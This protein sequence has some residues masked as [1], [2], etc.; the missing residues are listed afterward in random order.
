MTNETIFGD[1]GAAMNKCAKELPPWF[2][3]CLFTEEGYAWVELHHN[4]DKIWDCGG[5]PDHNFAEK[6]LLALDKAKKM[7]KMIK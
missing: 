3:I 4:G 1:L 2:Q 7:F 6:Y 5:H